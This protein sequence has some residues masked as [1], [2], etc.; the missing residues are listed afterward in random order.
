[1]SK[2]EKILVADDEPD[3]LETLERLIKKLRPG[4]SIVKATDGLHA[5]QMARNEAFGLIVTDFRMP[6]LD[7][8]K[9][10]NA[11]RDNPFNRK[12]P[13]VVLSGFVDE[14]KEEC[15]YFKLDR[16]LYLEK[17]IQSEEFVKEVNSF[18]ENLGEA[19]K[20]TIVNNKPSAIKLDVNFINPF[21]NAVKD[22][23]TTLGGVKTLDRKSMA[24]I[25]KEALI[26]STNICGQIGINSQYFSGRLSVLFP[27]KTFLNVANRILDQKYEAISETNKDVIGEIANIV[28]GTAKRTLN[29]SGYA[30]E[31]T[32]PKIHTDV[33]LALENGA[34]QGICIEFESDAGPMFVALEIHSVA[35]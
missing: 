34:P 22:T 31:P 27:S 9:L 5:Y 20:S 18:I 32:L 30:I 2:I 10:I 3:N 21:L 15:A 8:A 12:T 24:P 11:L 19:T 25:N 4:S 1:M 28:H 16:V 7:G 23:L 14:A 13:T 6:R 29:E 33:K 35:N 26:A 17:P